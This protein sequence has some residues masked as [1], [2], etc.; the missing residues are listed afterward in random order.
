MLLGIG[1]AIF[2]GFLVGTFHAWLVTVVKLPPFVA[3]DDPIVPIAG[4]DNVAT[5]ANLAVERSN[6]GGHCGFLADYRLHSWLDEYL[7]RVLRN[8]GGGAQSR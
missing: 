2:V 3:N 5:N 8:V 4:L 6:H 1:A 7:M